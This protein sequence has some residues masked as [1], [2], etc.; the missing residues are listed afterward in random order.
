MFWNLLHPVSIAR[1]VN[2][3]WMSKTT[4]V[5]PLP[6]ARVSGVSLSTSRYSRSAPASI[7]NLATSGY[8]PYAAI[9]IGAQPHLSLTLTLAPF[10]I[11]SATFSASPSLAAWRRSA[12]ELKSLNKTEA[13]RDF[14][15]RPEDEDEDEDVVCVVLLLDT[16]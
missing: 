6:S 11:R 16:A 9:L 3:S 14:F 2:S 4:S 7:S 13:T 12:S 10:A 5:R 1:L 8:P 15:R